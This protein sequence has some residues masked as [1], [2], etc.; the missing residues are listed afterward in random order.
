MSKIIKALEKAEEAERLAAGNSGGIIVSDSVPARTHASV[1]HA[2]PA[3]PA[4]AAQAAPATPV[5]TGRR[6][7]VEVRYEQTKVEQ[8][9]FHR[10]E[11]RRL[12]GE[13]APRELR[14]AFNVVR[15]RIL[16]QTR[17][18]GLNTIMVTSPGRGEGKTT[19]A[20]NLAITIA[21]DASQTA[22]LVDANLRW[23][24]ISCGLG[25]ESRPGL[26][27]HFLRGLSV[28]SLFVNP[29]INKLVVLPAGGSQEDSVDIISSPGMQSLVAEMKSRYP[30]R[31]VI[32]DCP[33]LI[34]LPDALV[35]TEYVDGIVLVVDEGKT[36]QADLKAALGMLEGR[37]LL[38]LVLNRA[39]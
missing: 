8:A 36:S 2:E 25:M 24:G 23:P 10:M 29:G 15:T 35:F 1:A 13:G 14:D 22:L 39:E 5:G 31:Y 9:C 33:H 21:R 6:D 26:S 28:E 18:R 37:N 12:L 7:S 38:G 3:A 34:G 27:D 16:Q 19:V 11:E 32:F 4:P 20:T 17:S 30:D